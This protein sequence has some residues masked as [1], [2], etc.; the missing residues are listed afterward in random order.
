[1]LLRHPLSPGVYGELRTF[2]MSYTC[3]VPGIPGFSAAGMLYQLFPLE[4][5]PAHAQ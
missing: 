1:M 5:T 4:V 2:H 3:T